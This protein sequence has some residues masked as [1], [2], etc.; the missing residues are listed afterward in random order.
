MVITKNWMC[1][2]SHELPNNLTLLFYDGGPLSAKGN[3]HIC[4]VTRIFF[5]KDGMLTILNETRMEK[6]NKERGDLNIRNLWKTF[7]LNRCL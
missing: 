1:E 4:Q 6:E 3:I 5:L 7:F 2:L